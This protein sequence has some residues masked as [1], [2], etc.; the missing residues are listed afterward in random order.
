MGIVRFELTKPKHWFYRPAQLSNVDVFPKKFTL[1]AD[2]E[3][4]A[5]LRLVIG[6]LVA[7]N[8]SSKSSVQSITTSQVSK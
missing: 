6:R 5:Y 4:F 8:H 7:F 1:S 2:N 3:A